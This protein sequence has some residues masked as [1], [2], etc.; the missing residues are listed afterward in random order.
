MSRQCIA[1]ILATLLSF[2]MAV[3]ALAGQTVFVSILPQQFFVNR[4]AGDLADVHVLVPPGA[5]PHTYEPS[6]RQM[7]A[8]SK[9]SAYFT[10]GVEFE[11][12]WLPRLRG[13]NPDLRF[14]SAEAGITK[15]PMAGR[16][17]HDGDE[18]KV[19]GPAHAGHDGDEILDPH[20]WLAPDNA[21]II[22]RNTC[23]GL[24][25]IDPG[26]AETYRANLDALLK[27]IETTDGRLRDILGPIPKDR[28]MFMVF[29]PSWGYFARQ[30]DLTQLPIESKGN[31]P[32]PRDLAEIIRHGR[33]LGI[34]VIFVQPQFSRRSAKVIASELDAQIAVLDPLSEDW[35]S[36]M[37]SVGEAFR[38]ASQK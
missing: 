12:A 33:E 35:E 11:K 28:R 5:S 9:A 24:V 22:A 18:A 26:H 25:A 6:P 2:A 29:H 23:Q 17:E 19:H 10:I 4:I 21:R 3:P 32:S 20:I 38:K 27:D 7:V 37:I 16:H 30:Y 14:I 1:F 8:L 36:N 31:E 13:A 34:R 15:I